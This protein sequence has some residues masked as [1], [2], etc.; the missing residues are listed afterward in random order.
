ME[1]HTMRVFNTI[2]LIILKLI[3]K[4]NETSIKIIFLIECLRV[5]PQKIKKT[6]TER[7]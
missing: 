7:G 3:Y 6:D 4:L 5:V 1:K 2:T